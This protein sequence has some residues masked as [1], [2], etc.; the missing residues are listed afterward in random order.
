MDSPTRTA[1]TPML[2]ARSQLAQSLALEQILRSLSKAIVPALA[3][4]LIVGFGLPTTYCVQAL[5]VGGGIPLLLRMPA[6]A[7]LGG[8][9]AFGLDSIK[10]GFRFLRSWRLLKAT[11]LIDGSATVFGSPTVLFPA[12]GMTVLGGDAVTVGLL[13]AAPGAGALVAATL[14]GWVSRTAFRAQR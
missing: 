10:D 9:T 11:F 3:G 7:P 4:V 12:L 5:L 1:I 8:G 6:M 2:V 14:S 13:Y